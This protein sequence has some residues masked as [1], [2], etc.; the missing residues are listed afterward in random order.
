MP[1]PH[2]ITLEEHFTSPKLKALRGEKD[3]PVQ[4]KLD[5]LGALRIAEMDEA[6]SIYRSYPRII[7]RRRISMPRR[8]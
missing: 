5:D 8:R 7:R 2:I 4:R 6:A 1:Q 3:T